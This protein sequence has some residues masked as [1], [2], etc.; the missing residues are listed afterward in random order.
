MF[1]C[2]FFSI[3]GMVTHTV[4]C[5]CLESNVTNIRTEGSR[6]DFYSLFYKICIWNGGRDISM[7]KTKVFQSL[8]LRKPQHK[9]MHGKQISKK[10]CLSNLSVCC[11]SKG[12]YQEFNHILTFH[13]NKLPFGR[14]RKLL[15]PK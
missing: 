3:E 11:C 1:L 2:F 7:S 6:D 8:A 10:Y 9:Y 5:S 14:H 13:N 15:S 4:L 12:V